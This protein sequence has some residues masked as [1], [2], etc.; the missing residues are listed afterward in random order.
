MYLPTHMLLLP[1]QMPLTVCPA[2]FLPFASQ[3]LTEMKME[4]ATAAA[5][6]C[7][8]VSHFVCQLRQLTRLVHLHQDV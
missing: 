3:A 1:D 7:A 5:T 8:S 4:A 2:R 6:V